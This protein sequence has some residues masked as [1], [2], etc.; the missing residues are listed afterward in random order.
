MVRQGVARSLVDCGVI[1][2]TVAD[3]EGAWDKGA[4]NL[5]WEGYVCRR[6]LVIFKQG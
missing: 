2:P 1:L 5:A 6:G 3:G 4:E